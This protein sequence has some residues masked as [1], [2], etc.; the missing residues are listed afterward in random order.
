MI[1]AYKPKFASP[2]PGADPVPFPFAPLDALPLG[3]LS[4]EPSPSSDLWAAG[5]DTFLA[6]FS[7]SFFMLAGDLCA[8]FSLGLCFAVLFSSGVGFVVG[9]ALGLGV[10]LGVDLGVGLGDGFGV[11]EGLGFD[12]GVGFGVVKFGFGVG[13]I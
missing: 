10:A 6:I 4:E 1:S 13:V 11:V 7:S 2:F 8:R 12:D 3:G 5:D 9:L